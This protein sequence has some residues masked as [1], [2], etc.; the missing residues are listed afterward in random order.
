MVLIPFILKLNLWFVTC[1]NYSNFGEKN[2]KS[3]FVLNNVVTWAFMG[4]TC[5]KDNN[6]SDMQ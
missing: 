3:N 1:W 5:S 6:V 4:I 2:S